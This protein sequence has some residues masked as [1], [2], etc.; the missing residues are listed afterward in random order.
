MQPPPIRAGGPQDL[1][2]VTWVDLAAWAGTGLAAPGELDFARRRARLASLL[3]SGQKL[4]VAEADARVAGYMLLQPQDGFLAQLFVAPK[5]QGQG[6]G[7][8][9]LA[10]ARAEQ[11]GGLWLRTPA[12]NRRAIDWYQREGFV[13]D[14]ETVHERPPHRLMV[15]YRW[16]PAGG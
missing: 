6:I 7:R 15:K 11:P 3:A 1:D 12:D 14:G 2:A 16:T 4:F 9:L 13:K 10:L 8:A 5:R